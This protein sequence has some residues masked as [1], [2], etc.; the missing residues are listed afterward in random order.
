MINTKKG[1]NRLAIV[2]SIIIAIGLSQL[3]S[4]DYYVSNTEK[5]LETRTI[6]KIT[7][8]DPHAL[9]ESKSKS[10]G[11][12]LFAELAEDAGVTFTVEKSFPP[13][14]WKVSIVRMVSGIVSFLLT[15]SLFALVYFT[16]KWI[17]DGFK[18]EQKDTNL[19]QKQNG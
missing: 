11:R 9:K 15:Y 4:H 19:K 12:N 1:L 14:L 5:R 6:R 2:L 17:I 18:K 8:P 16:V 7:K 13:P 10:G 3:F